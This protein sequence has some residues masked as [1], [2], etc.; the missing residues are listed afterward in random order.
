MQEVVRKSKRLGHVVDFRI[1]AGY[2]DGET[3][4]ELTD[5]GLRFIGRLKSNA[6]LERLA[7][8]HI[9]RPVGRPPK[10]GYEDVI[11]LGKYQAESWRHAQRLL[12]VIIDRPDPKTRQRRA[13]ASTWAAFS[14]TC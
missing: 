7:A 1:D 14:A 9:W 8:P 13:V 10:G 2:T 5:A 11:E 3:L 12:L 4:D 6:V